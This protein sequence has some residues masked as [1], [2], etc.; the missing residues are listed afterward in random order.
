M[1]T[2]MRHESPKLV[3][4]LRGDAADERIGD[5]VHVPG[6]GRPGRGFLVVL[7]SLELLDLLDVMCAVRGQ[8]PA[9]RLDGQVRVRHGEERRNFLGIGD[10]T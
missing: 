1:A 10:E 3:G 4:E 9:Q 2:R 7:A 6:H 8:Q 5:H